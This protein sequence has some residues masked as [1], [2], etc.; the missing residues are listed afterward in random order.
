M[1]AHRHAER[2]GH[3]PCVPGDGRPAQGVMRPHSPQAVVRPNQALRRLPR[4]GPPLPD[5][6]AAWA[7]P[8]RPREPGCSRDLDSQVELHRTARLYLIG[9]ERVHR[10]GQGGGGHRDPFS[11]R[12]AG[13]TAWR[14]PG[15]GIPLPLWVLRPRKR[16]HSPG[17]RLTGACG[18]FGRSVSATCGV[19]ASAKRG[20]TAESRGWNSCG[21]IIGFS[22]HRAG[23][24]VTPS[25]ILCSQTCPARRHILRSLDHAATGSCTS[26]RGQTLRRRLPVCQGDMGGDHRP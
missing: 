13:V 4:Q 3:V 12:V 11:A 17:A 6:T 8:W 23:F 19:H 20:I 24:R 7:A 9:Q 16:G 14:A 2:P 5:T 18:R 15:R 10:G 26:V 1:L 22:S 21:R 25:T